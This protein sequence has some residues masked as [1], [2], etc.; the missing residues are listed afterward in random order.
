MPNTYLAHH[1]IMGMKWGVRRFQNADGTLTERGKKRFAK[2]ESSSFLQKKD[3]RAM[4]RLLKKEIRRADSAELYQ[5]KSSE[6]AYIQANKDMKRAEQKARHHA[7]KAKDQLTEHS[8]RQ[9]ENAHKAE[10]AAEYMRKR[11][12]ELTK[13]L[14][15]VNSGTLKAGRDYIIQ[16]DYDNV[17]FFK[18]EKTQT[19]IRKP[20]E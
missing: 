10:A 18:F 11:S 4:K 17:G 3:T 2:V 9:L 12:A 14:N 19:V 15:E 8:N 5:T 6:Q 16:R 20:Q 1:G 13:T 7:N